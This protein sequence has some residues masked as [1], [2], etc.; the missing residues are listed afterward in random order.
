MFMRNVISLP[1]KVTLAQGFMSL[2]PE[3]GRNWGKE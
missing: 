3:S 1:R 2:G